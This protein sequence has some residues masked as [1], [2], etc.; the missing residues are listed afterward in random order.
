MIEFI[1][2]VCSKSTYVVLFTQKFQAGSLMT[3]SNIAQNALHN[4]NILKLGNDI[5]Q[6]YE[7]YQRDVI[8][9]LRHCLNKLKV[10]EVALV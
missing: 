3:R 6:I 9:L 2:C 10:F 5:G 4:V 7:F 1:L 8:K